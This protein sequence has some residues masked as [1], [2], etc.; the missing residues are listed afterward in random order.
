MDPVPSVLMKVLATFCV[1]FLPPLH[2]CSATVCALFFFT[3]AWH[4]RG[5]TTECSRFPC[6]H[7]RT[8]TH[9]FLW[10][11]TLLE[12]AGF[13]E[14]SGWKEGDLYNRNSNQ[15]SLTISHKPFATHSQFTQLSLV[16]IFPSSSS[17]FFLSLHC[18]KFQMQNSLILFVVYLLPTLAAIDTLFD[19]T[20]L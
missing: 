10:W 7:T 12:A 19:S 17:F 18:S 6:L 2:P 3:S 8:H 4:C 1:S 16:Y 13:T 20:S 14:D 5:P 11:E 15:L 9:P